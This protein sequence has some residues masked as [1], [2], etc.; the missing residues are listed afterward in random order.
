MSQKVDEIVALA[1]K[2]GPAFAELVQ[3]TVDLRARGFALSAQ[4]EKLR[5]H[6]ES[7]FPDLVD[8]VAAGKLDPEKVP[9]HTASLNAWVFDSPAS[10]ILHQ[11]AG[12][13]HA[14][15]DRA[16]VAAVPALWQELARQAGGCVDESVSLV[17]KKLP[18]DVVNES[19][20]FKSQDPQVAQT[21]HRLRALVDHWDKIHELAW[22]LMESSI[23]DGP[24]NSEPQVQRL[25]ARWVKFMDPTRLV[26]GYQRQAPELKLAS[27]KAS[28]AGPGLYDWAS[29]TARWRK[30]ALKTA[31][32]GTADYRA[33][34]HVPS[35]RVL[36]PDEI[37]PM[38]G[39]PWPGS[40][41]LQVPKLP[42]RMVQ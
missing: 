13:A 8:L 5:K 19:T 22:S 7:N 11:A 24:P 39:M 17:A 10:K 12:L 14:Q 21:W 3:P 6:E 34:H 25:P 41:A 37:D 33:A 31:E 23:V 15:A 26:N 1:R 35:T 36:S 20:A 28:G 2:L 9:S 18:R 42:A 4:L 27:A 30:W 40:K 32:I 29:A 16:L 38:T